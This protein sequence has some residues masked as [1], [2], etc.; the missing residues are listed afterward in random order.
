[1]TRM[2]FYSPV[3]LKLMLRDEM[4]KSKIPEYMGYLV[5][6]C[7]LLPKTQNDKDLVSRR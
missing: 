5:I 2:L 4:S 3:E 1:M 6:Q 7:T